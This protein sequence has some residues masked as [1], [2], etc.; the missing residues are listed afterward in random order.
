ML[1]L[2]IYSEYRWRTFGICGVGRLE[3]APALELSSLSPGTG[4][5][6]IPDASLTVGMRPVML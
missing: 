2:V 6:S 5:S 3:E 4:G 1:L